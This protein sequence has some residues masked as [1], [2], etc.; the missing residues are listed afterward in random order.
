MNLPALS[1][2]AVL[3]VGGFGVTVRGQQPWSVV[4]EGS[5]P[6]NA[7]ARGDGQFIA[8]GESGT[9]LTSATGEDW[10]PRTIPGSTNAS[11]W[12]IAFGQGLWVA[13][14]GRNTGIFTSADGIRWSSVPD[15]PTD[16]SAMV[17]GAGTFVGVA[18]RR[19]WASTNG[20]AWKPVFPE[21]YVRDRVLV[22]GDGRFVAQRSVGGAQI[23]TSTN[24]TDWAIR[25]GS[26]GGS[27]YSMAYGD[28]RF[29]AIDISNQTFTSTDL[30][31]WV[32]G[33]MTQIFRPSGIAYAPGAFVTVGTGDPELTVAGVA[34]SPG[35]AVGATRLLAVAAGEA[36]FIAVGVA[37]SILRSGG[38]L[39]VE[40]EAQGNLSILGPGG[41]QYAI[42]ARDS[43]A[44][45]TPWR[46]VGEV[47]V[48]TNAATW[49]DPDSP[50]HPTRLYRV[51]GL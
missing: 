17:H 19:L 42:E 27:F 39:I 40:T 14:G 34:W 31:T 28:G 51:V 25:S 9:V 22:F 7:I 32:P 3:M 49:L 37:G 50:N 20:I 45:D 12:T 46:P 5:R 8:V 16:W 1:L 6:L 41:G 24:G 35:G 21:A 11:L 29:L 47:T 30:E 2:V 48:G 44:E 13:G 23:L 38:L 43:L 15:S 33:G 18:A 26:P 4:H 36:A 10:T